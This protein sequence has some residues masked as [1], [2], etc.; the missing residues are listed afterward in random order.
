MPT[1]L[2]TWNHTRWEWEDFDAALRSVQSGEPLLDFWSTGN[3]KQLQP[4]DHF[5]LFRQH[6]NQGI[7]GSGIVTSAVDQRPHWDGSDRK[8]NYVDVEFRHLV[9]VQDVLSIG[10]LENAIPAVRWKRIQGSGITVPVDQEQSLER[11]W[12]DHLEKLG[13]APIELP[14][15]V[16]DPGLFLEGATHQIWVNA[17]ERNPAARRACIAYY[18]ARCIV[19]GFSFGQVFGDLGE[20]Y[21]H[22]HHLLDLAT[23]GTEYEVDPVHDLRPIC[24]N[25]HAMLHRQT[26][27]MSVEKLKDILGLSIRLSQSR[28]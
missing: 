21:I 18:G 11:L 27:A 3:N 1:Y 9:S 8:S 5:F 17:Y 26:P 28:Q 23:I 22:V 13:L 7:I 20:G 10:A 16:M 25:C 12:L 2:L 6:D 24:P 14:G 19:C 4:D 15:E